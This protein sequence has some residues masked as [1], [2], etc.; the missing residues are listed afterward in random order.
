MKLI[1]ADI[2]VNTMKKQM[3]EILTNAGKKVNPNDY[4]V[5]LNNA[6]MDT[7]MKSMNDSFIEFLKAQP[8]I[9]AEPLRHGRWVGNHRHVSCSCCGVTFCIPDGEIG[10]LDMSFYKYCP[11]CGAKMDLKEGKK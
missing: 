8:A 9:E 4:Y 1:D 7:V 2:I 10:E 11:K 3:L 6:Y 5:K